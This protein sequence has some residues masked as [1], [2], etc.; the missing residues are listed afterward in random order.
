M[1]LSMGV[2]T[3]SDH[4]GLLFRYERDGVILNSL[5]TDFSGVLENPHLHIHVP[6]ICLWRALTVIS[7][8]YEPCSLQLHRSSLLPHCPSTA[9]MRISICT[10]Q[11][12]SRLFEWREWTEKQGRSPYLL[13]SWE[14]RLLKGPIFFWLTGNPWGNEG[15]NDIRRFPNSKQSRSTSLPREK[16]RGAKWIK[17]EMN[18]LHSALLFPLKL[19]N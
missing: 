16:Q 6:K 15:R 4:R 10:V 19:K 1:G 9:K 18:D 7:I 13:L 3:P 8:R 2:W 5:L 17:A 11:I 12:G 14:Q